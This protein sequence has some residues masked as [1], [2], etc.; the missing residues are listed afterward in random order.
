[1]LGT[2]VEKQV[3]EFLKT[4]PPKQKTQ[5]AIKILQLFNDPR[6]ND[7]IKLK[8]GDGD[9]RTDIGEYRISYSFSVTKGINILKVGKRNGGEVYD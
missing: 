4:L 2:N 1:M 5:I 3:F 7:S 8:G 9:Y 6:P